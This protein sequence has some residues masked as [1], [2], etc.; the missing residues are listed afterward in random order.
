MPSELKRSLELWAGCVAGALSEDEYRAKLGSAGF[1]EIEIEAV[2]EYTADDAASGGLGEL[3]QRYARQGAEGLGI[4]SAIVR[5]R[6][7]G[8]GG[9]AAF[10]PIEVV[11][12]SGSVCGQ[13]ECC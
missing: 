1:G 8:G 5:A 10:E 9:A 12:A 3:V 7:P 11:A 2:R 4:F 13:G 6:K